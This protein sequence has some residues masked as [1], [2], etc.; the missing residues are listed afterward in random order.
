MALSSPAAAALTNGSLLLEGGRADEGRYQCVATLQG[1]GTILSRIARVS[2]Q[3]KEM[4]DRV[5][6]YGGDGWGGGGGLRGDG[7]GP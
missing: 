6:F 1:V 2:F 7:L 5:P 4:G 3:G